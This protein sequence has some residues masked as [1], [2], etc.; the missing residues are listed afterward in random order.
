MGSW[1][2]SK[3]CIWNLGTKLCR[4]VPRKRNISRV[5]F[6]EFVIK[7]KEQNSGLVVST[8]GNHSRGT[9]SFPS[10]SQCIILVERNIMGETGDLILFIL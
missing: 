1:Y 5:A 7:L 3:E 4:F 9:R 10:E 8:I 2:F 6:K